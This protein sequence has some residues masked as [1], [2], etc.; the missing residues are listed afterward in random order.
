MPAETDDQSLTT[1]ERFLIARL[2]QTREWRLDVSSKH[3]HHTYSQR[4]HAEKFGISLWQY[5]RVERDEAV[6]G[7]PAPDVH[8]LEEHERLLLRRVRL[9]MTRRSLARALGVSVYWVYRMEHGEV[10]LDRLREY[11]LAAA[12]R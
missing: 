1:G 4:A 9:R 3:L 11:W 6:L 7:K 5:R 10:P 8:P 12:R 2:R